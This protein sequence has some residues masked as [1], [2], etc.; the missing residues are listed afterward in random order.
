MGSISSF[1]M[2]VRGPKETLTN[3][4]AMNLYAA[5]KGRRVVMRVCICS[6]KRTTNNIKQI[7]NPNTNG[8]LRRSVKASLRSWICQA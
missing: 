5:P 6:V 4:L 1:N 7:T 2:R 8:L 3:D